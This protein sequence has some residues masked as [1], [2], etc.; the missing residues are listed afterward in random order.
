MRN[1][2]IDTHALIE[3]PGAEATFR[4]CRLLLARKVLW[5]DEPGLSLGQLAAALDTTTAMVAEIVGALSREGWVT[6]DA[7]GERPVLTTRGVA[8]IIGR[9]RPPAAAES[10]TIP[11][12]AELHH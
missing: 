1:D 5:D 7:A 6:V 2:C 8:A 10:P 4:L 12:G 11:A 3:G 9:P